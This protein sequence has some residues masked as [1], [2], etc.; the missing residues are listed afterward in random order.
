MNNNLP[1]TLVHVITESKA[2]VLT[3]G[4]RNSLTTSHVSC[5]AERSQCWCTACWYI[6]IRFHKQGPALFVFVTCKG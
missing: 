1:H 4:V 3:V 5:V 2:K 6:T